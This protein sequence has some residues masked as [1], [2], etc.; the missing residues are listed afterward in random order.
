MTCLTCQDRYDK[1]GRGP[2]RH[3]CPGRTCRLALL[4]G[5]GLLHLLLGPFLTIILALD[6]H[7]V[8]LYNS[9]MIDD[10]QADWELT[11]EELAELDEMLRPPGAMP[12]YAWLQSNF[13]TKSAA[14]RYL[15]TQG[16]QVKE[17]S[18]H[19][20]LKYRHVFGV[21][22][23]FKSEAVPEHVCP[24]CKNRRG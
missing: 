17:I 23:K 19:L 13:K 2:V 14:I 6:Y 16:F 4:L 20:G 5:P 22:H 24:V 7:R 1:S 21:I 3:V 15:H 12:S 11:E 18:Q 9:N 8:M 10:E